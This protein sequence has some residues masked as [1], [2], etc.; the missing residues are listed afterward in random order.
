MA[1]Q[2]GTARGNLVQ[3]KLR[4]TQN[5]AYVRREHDFRAIHVSSLRLM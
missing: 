3:Y 4:R 1:A 5:A 2:I